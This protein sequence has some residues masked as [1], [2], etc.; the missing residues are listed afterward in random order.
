MNACPW[1][2]RVAMCLDD[3]G[4]DSELSKHLDDCSECSE[5][6]AD[7]RSDGALVALPPELP[8]GAEQDFKHSVSRELA[9]RRR[10][11]W[12]AVI[13]ALAASLALVVLN[14]PWIR[15]AETPHVAVDRPAAFPPRSETPE[16]AASPTVIPPTKVAVRHARPAG[17]R[18]QAKPLRVLAVDDRI[19][20][21]KQTADPNVIILLVGDGE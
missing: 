11:K 2:E 13:A 7:L 15:H 12:T 5:L 1:A 17:H 18:T 21:E 3:V 6:L 20:V 16:A 10:R 14:G 8:V 19:V 9:R 4:P